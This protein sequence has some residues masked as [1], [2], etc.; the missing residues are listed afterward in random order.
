MADSY[1][2]LKMINSIYKFVTSKQDNLPLY[3]GND[4]PD[5]I[6]AEI[7]D[8][9]IRDKLSKHAINEISVQTLIDR[10]TR[11]RRINLASLGIMHDGKLVLEHY[12]PPYTREYRH[13]TFSMSK[14][15]VSMAVGIA[16]AKGILS[17]KDKLCEIFTEHSGIFMKKNIKEITIENLLT[18]TSGVKFDELSSYFS[19]DWCKA[20][21]GS[22]TSFEPGTSFSYNSINTY[23]LAAAITRKSGMTVMDFLKENLFNPLAIHDIT[24]DKCPIGIEKGGWG[25]KLSL[26]GMLKFGQLYLNKGVWNVNGKDVQILSRK[27][28]E[29]SIK[30][31][32][33]IKD[34]E[35]I[36]GYGYSIWL[37]SDGS[38]LFNGIFG[39]NVYINP[40]RNMV[41]ATTAS[42]YEFFPDGKL[43]EEICNFA[44]DNR[45]FCRQNSFSMFKNRVYRLRRGLLKKRLT[46]GLD[47]R[48]YLNPY[49]D[50]KYRFQ[51]YASS[52]LPITSQVLYSNFLTGIEWLSIRFNNRRLMLCVSD[53]GIG[54]QLAVGYLNDKQYEYQLLEINGK[55]MPV[56]VSGRVLYDEDERM[57]L[58]I[59]IIFLEE[60][61]S[62]LLKIYFNR[63]D[64]ELKAYEIPN[65]LELSD[66]IF[67]E[68]LM[69][70]TKKLGRVATPDYI[71]YKIQT[72]LTPYVRGQ[73]DE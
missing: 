6:K 64:I 13:V 60:T 21:M 16:E 47:I 25:M 70:R 73:A 66:K 22:D 67:G 49:F 5:F 36:R 32:F 28:V 11:N 30:C 59:K 7:N 15:V 14:S 68:D 2:K 50:V 26:T 31:H 55:K 45:N 18:M 1:L 63:E 4:I 3:H 8:G 53:G 37:L 61:V 35:Y 54:Y 71:K 46:S 48:E 34:K 65:M 52:I 27:W 12:V 57:L 24:W 42:A 38:Y 41:L 29:D 39:Q 58:Q 10:L 20:F 33:A 62:K 9:L 43:I 56:A 72:V 19:Y 51:E 23:M 44:R 17:V 40:K 69:M